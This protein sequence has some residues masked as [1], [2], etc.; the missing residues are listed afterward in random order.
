M[1]CIKIGEGTLKND[2]LIESG[3]TLTNQE[4]QRKDYAFKFVS[5]LS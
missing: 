4:F 2:E 3:N 5:Y 1:I